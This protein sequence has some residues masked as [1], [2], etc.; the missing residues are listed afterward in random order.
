VTDDVNDV[1]ENDDDVDCVND[2]DLNGGVAVAVL[3]S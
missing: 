1:N 2:D 3:K